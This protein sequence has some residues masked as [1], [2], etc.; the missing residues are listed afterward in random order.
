[1]AGALLAE[2]QL[3]PKYLCNSEKAISVAGT[4][5]DEISKVKVLKHVSLNFLSVSLS[6]FQGNLSSFPC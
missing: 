3:P 1:M 6:F 4:R 5:T 2:E